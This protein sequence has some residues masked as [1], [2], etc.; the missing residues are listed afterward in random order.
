LEKN[1]KSAIVKK[2]RTTK[3]ITMELI[4]VTEAKYLEDYKIA[5]TFND[6]LKKVVD[7]KSHLNGKIFKPLNN[8]EN[9]KRFYVSDWTIE[10]SNGADM[11]PEFL[12][13]L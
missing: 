2:D 1:R 10:W 11:S 8:I 7:L 9:F 5:L 13:S 12:Y 6:G 3:I 4:W